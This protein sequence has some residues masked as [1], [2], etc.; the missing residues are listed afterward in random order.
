MGF[1]DERVRK[2][3]LGLSFF[4]RVKGVYFDRE[5]YKICQHR[6]VTEKHMLLCLCL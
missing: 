5:A 4:A 6:E 2:F 1:E 3:E